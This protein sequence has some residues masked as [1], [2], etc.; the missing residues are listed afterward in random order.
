MSLI[1][2]I[3]MEL[4]RLSG[5]FAKQIKELPDGTQIKLRVVD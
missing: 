3:Q 5:D 4:V 1:E 2:K